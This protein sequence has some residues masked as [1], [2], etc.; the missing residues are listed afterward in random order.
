MI[1]RRKPATSIR[2]GSGSRSLRPKSSNRMIEA[3]IIV[4]KWIETISDRMSTPS[5]PKTP[6]MNGMPSSTVLE[7]DAETPPTTPA[8]LSRPK[9]CVRDKGS[10]SPGNDH[11]REIGR[12]QPPGCGAVEIGLDH[13]AEEQQRQRDTDGELRQPLPGLRLQIAGP[14]GEIAE[15][16]EPEDEQNGF[17]ERRHDRLIGERETNGNLRH[18]LVVSQF[19]VSG[20]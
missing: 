14:A 15:R 13:G 19:E 7:N 18:N 12:P 8:A 17:G 4:G 11:R 9:I 1:L 6:S 20:S 3:M 2:A 16:D 5:C 10:R